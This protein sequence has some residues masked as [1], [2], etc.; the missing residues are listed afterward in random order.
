MSSDLYRIGDPVPLVFLV[1]DVNGD[2]VDPPSV[3][4]TIARP[5]GT[6]V[7]LDVTHAGTGSYTTDYVPTIAGRHT[8]RFMATGPDGG[9]LEDAFDVLASSLGNPTLVE[10][11]EYLGQT[12]VTDTELGSA[13]RAEQTAQNARCRV[14]PYSPDLHEALC[15]R[16]ARNLAARRVPVAQYSSFEGGATTTRVPA[17]DPEIRRLE[18][19]Y[20]RRPLG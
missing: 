3:T 18:A 11:R 14:D 16:V 4:L 12:S 8:A 19:P 6:S 7:T 20:R 1:H 13:L 9:V 15:R 2:L 5:N 17:T 10:L